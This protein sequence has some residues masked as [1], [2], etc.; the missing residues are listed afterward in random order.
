MEAA[1]HRTVESVGREDAAR[2]DKSK[3]RR[4]VANGVVFL[5][6]VA[7]FGTLWRV[8]DELRPLP[9]LEEIERATSAGLWS[10]AESLSRRSLRRQPAEPELALVYGQALAQRGAFDSAARVFESVGSQGLAG[11]DALVRAGQAWVR[12]GARRRAERSWL[13]CLECE[14]V[15]GA[16]LY[17]QEC[18]RL[19]CG[20][21]ALERRRGDLWEMSR[22][23][24]HAALPAERH[25][26][27]AMRMRYEYELVQPSIALVELESALHHD[28][29]DAFTRRAVVLYWLEMDRLDEAQ[30][31]LEETPGPQRED[32]RILDAVLELANRVG[33]QS[34]LSAIVKRRMQANGSKPPV[35]L[36]KYA[37]IVAESEGDFLTAA[38][39]IRTAL[40]RNP[41]R[42]DLNHRLGQLLMRLGEPT[43][44][45]PI[46]ERAQRLHRIWES[47]RQAFEDYRTHWQPSPER[48]IDIAHRFARL[49]EQLESWDEAK[50]WCRAA[51]AE[52][53]AHATSIELWAQFARRRPGEPF[54]DTP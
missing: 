47:L 5:A 24:Y 16:A 48:R 2:K 41:D 33:D 51:L 31:C 27:L 43:K 25:E 12:V 1:A 8:F 14:S 13:A 45:R 10:E 49:Y 34:R 21:Y 17:Q 18:R 38:E 9:A 54:A 42:A 28:P 39:H 22:K 40:E 4:A 20:L 23:M 35:E 36:L 7:A 32:P 44:A 19:L 37:S 3:S 46:L 26:V 53:P 30:R 50:G 6:T 15:I 11:C 52:N 29:D